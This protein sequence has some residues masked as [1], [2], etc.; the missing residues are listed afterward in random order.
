MVESCVLA[1]MNTEFG[2]NFI[3]ELVEGRETRGYYPD[4]QYAPNRIVVVRKGLQTLSR[5]G[6]PYSTVDKDVS[7][8][9]TQSALC[10]PH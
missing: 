9:S 3:W 6:V 8:A 2:V 5:L 1:N 4:D 10:L 7:T